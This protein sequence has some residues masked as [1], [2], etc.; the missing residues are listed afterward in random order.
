PNARCVIGHDRQAAHA[1]PRQ[2]NPFNAAMA[3]IVEDLVGHDLVA[4]RN[5]TRIL[6]VRWL[7]IA[8]A[9]VADF[10]RALQSLGGCKCFP[11]AR[12]RA[13]EADRD[14]VVSSE[15]LEAAFTRGDSAFMCGVFG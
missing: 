13:S 6:H 7:E 15:P 9:V 4:A 8:D 11:V 1:A 2:E 5:T 10:P 12:P 3:E 14:E